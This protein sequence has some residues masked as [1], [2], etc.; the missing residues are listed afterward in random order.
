MAR[1]CS[2]CGKGRSVG[3]N[4]SHANNKNKRVFQPNL[5]RVKV[6]INKTPKRVMVCTRCLRSNLVQKAI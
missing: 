4:V 2:V 3:N 6:L 1:A 5:Q